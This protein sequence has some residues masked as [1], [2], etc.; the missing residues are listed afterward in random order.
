MKPYHSLFLFSFILP[1]TQATEPVAVNELV[2]SIVAQ[3]PERRFYEEAITAARADT[4]LAGRRADPELSFDVGRKRV[5]SG[6]ALA[7]EG[8]AWSVSLTQTFDWP[9]R[10]ALRKALANHDLQL[11][12]LG[13][14]RFNRALEAQARE[15]AQGLSAAHT[16]A[17]AV[18]EVADRFSDLKATF[19]ARDPAGITPLLETRVIE[20]AELSLQRRATDAELAVQAALLEL[21]QL[22]GAATD[23]PL[24]VSATELAFRELPDN[25]ALLAA[26]RENNFDY[27]MRRVE[28]E[29][30]GVAVDLARSERRPGLSVSPFVSQEKAGDRETVVGLGFSLPLPLPGRTGATISAAESRRRQAEVALYV[31]QREL[32]RRVLTAAQTYRSKSAELSRWA[33]E[34]LDAFRDAAALADRHYRLG[35]IPIATYV[36]LQTSYLDAV[37]ALLDLQAEALTAGLELWELTG[38]DLNPVNAAQ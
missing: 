32:E 16:K 4:K 3:N 38:L 2:T 18:R 12:E 17:Q 21:N 25:P 19:L 30:Q 28:L 27:A 29:Q 11:A 24:R 15:L 35:A 1:F 34:T 26:A 5:H 8:T 9:G 33:P 23:A 37:E 20:A 36:E 13:L 7:A 10:L 22:R 6:N 14:D 31:A